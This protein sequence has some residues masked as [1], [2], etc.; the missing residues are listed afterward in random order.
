SKAVL[1]SVE[2]V[3]NGTYPI[4]RE[5][6]WFFNG[7]PTGEMK[8]LLDFTLSPEGQKIAKETDYI[9]LPAKK[10]ANE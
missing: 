3:S 7:E 4:S 9:P 1:P 2:T 8:K 5:L 6:Y 10:M